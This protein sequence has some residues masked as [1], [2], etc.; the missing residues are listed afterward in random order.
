M[1]I[2]V[3][4]AFIKD[5]HSPFHNQVKDIYIN[6]GV[7]QTIGDNLSMAADQT[8]E[9]DGLHVS[10]G[11]IDI[12][13][14]GTD[15][16][17]EFKDTLE[18]VAASAAQGGFTHVFLTPNTKPVTQQKT[19]IDYVSANRHNSPVQLHAIGAVSKNTDGK[20]LAEMH[21]M[22]AA[23]AIAFS[24]GNK[25][26]QSAGL[27]IKALQYL[28]A[29]GGTLIQIPD[30]QSVAPHGLM[31]EGVV[32]TQVGL[33]GKPALAEELMVARDIALC[34]YTRSALHIT[35]ITLSS[36]LDMIRNAKAEGL[37]ITCSTTTH[38]LTFTDQDLTRGYNTMLKLNPPL[39]TESDRQA[40]LAG[41]KDKTIDCITTHH[42]AQHLDAK[43][44]E[45]EYAGY[46]TLGLESA[47]GILG[48]QGL[49]TDEILFAICE[50]PRALFGLKSSITE[51]A[52]ADLS[53]FQ[54]DINHRFEKTGIRS[55][56]ANSAYIGMEL[57]GKSIAQILNNKNN[58]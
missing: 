30:D 57:K 37:P 36:S 20:E 3:R 44:C 49:S 54:P 53:F 21:E 10:P 25:S 7:I 38:H 41:V 45:F 8:I 42:T 2:I 43:V 31:H 23:G 39:R 6:Q 50:R 47:F 55:I 1:T 15:P 19:G 24:D 13:V 29:F 34:R 14:S 33:P 17:L 4:K 46:G 18:S 26:I 22:H 32:S 27:L 9:I 52:V 28:S 40:L 16:G 48:K 58:L 5:P 11:W 35:G 56:S 51:G 12:F